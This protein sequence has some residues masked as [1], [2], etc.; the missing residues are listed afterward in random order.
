VK[1]STGVPIDNLNDAV[2]VT[3]T[4]STSGWQGEMATVGYALTGITVTPYD[5]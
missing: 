3:G 1:F 2:W 5:G 4:L